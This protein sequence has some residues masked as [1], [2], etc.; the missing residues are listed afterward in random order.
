MNEK[1]L[2]EI[3]RRFRPQ[4]NSILSIKGCLVNGEKTIVSQF[5]QP[6]AV[7]SA[8][9]GEKLLSIM[10]KSLSGSLGTN[11]LELEF[12]A[13][14]AMESDRHHLL[15]ALRESRLKD[16]GALMAFYERVIASTHF[17]GSFAILLAFDSYDVFS[18]S[19]DGEKGD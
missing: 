15:M 7:C 9:E 18:C 6:M 1:E 14:Q 19:S 10:K 17:D 5:D 16:E 2:R 8:D 3:R 13:R 12:S 11:L 4:N